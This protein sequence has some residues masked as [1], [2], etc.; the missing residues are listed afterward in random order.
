MTPQVQPMLARR[1]LRLAVVGELQAKLQGVNVM[2]PGAWPTPPEK[3]PAV[4]VR[5]PREDKQSIQRG[6]PEF[7]TTC[8]IELLGQVQAATPEEAQDVIDDLAYQVEEAV[9]K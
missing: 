7:N 8:S 2:S 4:L 5:V 9:L 1:L 3:L 6:M